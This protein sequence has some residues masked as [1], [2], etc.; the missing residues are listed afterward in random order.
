MDTQSPRLRMSIVA[1]VVVS[2][3]GA[4]FARLWYLQVMAAP[5]Y[6][7]EAEAN[8]VRVI[9]EEA[10]RGRILDATGNVLVDN[11]TS[12]VVTIN[13]QDL[14]ALDEVE[15]EA[16]L[17]RLSQTLTG[18]GTPTKV[19]T[20]ER[21]LDD[22]QYDQLQPV[23]IAIDVSEELFLYLSERAEDFPSVEM[24]REPVRAYPHG[25]TAAH[26]LGYVGPI[27]EQEYSERVGDDQPKPYQPDSQIGKGGVEATFEDELRG[28]PGLRR[29][30]V[31]AK[32]RPVR[33][34]SYQAPEPG[35]DIQL[36]ID[37]AV[38][39]STET[40]LAE[41]LTATRSKRSSQSRA[42]YAAPA[43][44]AV[45]LD[46]RN[47]NVV[48]LAS[49][50]T[51]NPDDFVNGISLDRYAQLRDAPDTP[52]L[53][54]TIQGLYAPGSTFKPF[55]AVAAMSRG[56]LDANTFYE[57]RGV[58]RM[59]TGTF[60][61]AGGVRHGS[62]NVETSLRVSSNVFYAWLGH[63][64]HRERELVG[65]GVQDTARAFGLGAPTGIRLPAERPGVV[66][67]AAYKM[68]LW[69]SLPVDAR[70]ET[71]EWFPGDNVNTA[72]GQGDLLVSPLQLATA[73]G[74]IANGGTVYQPNIV[75]RVLRHGG[76]VNDPDAVI[77]VIEPHVNNQIELPPHM[78]DPIVRGLV[79]VT[80]E[81]GGT[82]VSTFQ[83]FNQTF[84]R[85]AGKTGTAEVRGKDDTSVF[86]AFAPADAPRFVTVAFLEESGYG[87]QAA[88]P[89]VRRILEPLA[90]QEVTELAN[91]AAG[92]SD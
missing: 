16:L 20:I 72:V 36:T 33:T 35:N 27:S 86:A 79:G 42:R 76:D 56:L 53:D 54:R 70:G 11:R 45:V 44:A 9:A 60:S 31:D 73:Y 24:R 29:I 4:L 62:V 50:P 43:G 37:L 13:R 32:N 21:R 41:Q 88:A 18:Y 85:V 63:R 84:F 39:Q 2:L 8:R 55:T 52:L 47:G 75:A 34:I 65:D 66:P 5:E 90:G 7:V 87:G 91:I 10:P 22:P 74:T 69:E 78:R 15:R 12:L 77:R 6:Q 83:G 23:P 17:L 14:G 49:Y 92:L 82:A 1:I 71:G 67:D 46:P 80:N 81:R 48:A 26:L 89:A 19:V 28:V 64:F 59:E 57:D 58:Y 68:Q 40:A 38:Q 61:N 3:F 30:E 51:F 25:T